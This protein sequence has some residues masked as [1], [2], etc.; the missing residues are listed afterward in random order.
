MSNTPN[1]NDPLNLNPPMEGNTP[2]PY[3]TPK[4]NKWLRCSRN[5]DKTCKATPPAD[6]FPTKTN[7]HLSHITLASSPSSFL[8][9]ASQVSSLGS[10]GCKLVNRILLL[11]V[12]RMRL[13]ELSLASAQ[14][15]STSVQPWALLLPLWNQRLKITDRQRFRVRDGNCPQRQ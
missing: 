10:K 11:K 1:E 12:R 13:L 9:L 15:S 14:S 6:S 8:F 5:M 3:L 2:N 7:V 4:L